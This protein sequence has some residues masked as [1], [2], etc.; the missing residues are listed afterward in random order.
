[1]PIFKRYVVHQDNRILFFTSKP[2]SWNRVYWEDYNGY[3]YRVTG[4]MPREASD[5][6][7][8]LE[9]PEGKAIEVEMRVKV[10]D[11]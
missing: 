5:Y 11:K 8:L 3:K 10:T 4:I 6:E 9:L 1:M 7:G 2:K